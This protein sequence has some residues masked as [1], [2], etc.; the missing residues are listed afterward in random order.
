MEKEKFIE[1]NCKLHGFTS[2][3]LEGSNSYRC[4]KCRSNAVQR[5]RDKVKIMSVEY[6]GGKCSKCGYNQCIGAL[7][8][9]HLDPLQKSFGIAYKGYTRSWENVKI[10]LDKCILLCAN[11]HRELEME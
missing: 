4:K 5:R 3:V 8:F 2:Y 7:E 9:H 11:C 1:K 10:E 6:K